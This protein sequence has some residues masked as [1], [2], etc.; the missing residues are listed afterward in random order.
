M[1]AATLPIIALDGPAGAGKSSVAR[2]LAI[3]LGLPYIDTGAMYRAVAWKAIRE[4][5]SL[6]CHEVLERIAE[7]VVLRFPVDAA[8]GEIEVDDFRLAGEI[9]TPDISQAASQVSAVP[10]VR[11]ALL[12]QQRQLG[13]SNG[14]VMEGRDIGTVVFPDAT[15]KFYLTASSMERARRRAEELR[16]KGFEASIAEVFLQVE[17]RD[18]RDAERD[19]APMK[20]ADDALILDTEGRSIESLV[21]EIFDRVRKVVDTSDRDPKL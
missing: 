14:C 19:I 20:P 5:V 21:D 10:G 9:R 4:G 18:R 7:Q 2:A 6:A 16:K 1:T 12:E 17:E 15:A 8:P 13:R 3:R 11:S